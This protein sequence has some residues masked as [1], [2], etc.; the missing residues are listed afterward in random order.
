MRST[1]KALAVAAATLAT[2][3]TGVGVASASTTRAASAPDDTATCAP[4]NLCLWSDSGFSGSQ[5]SADF[6]DE[7]SGW[8]SVPSSV[9]N[10]TS[11]LVNYRDSITWVA[12]Y[13][14]GTGHSACLTAGFSI[15]NLADV[16][17][18]GY[19]T[20]MNDSITSYKFDTSGTC[21]QGSV[22]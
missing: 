9:N 15:S 10:T 13:A 12:Q 4:Y 17:W 3:T 19:T 18:P 1:F 16:D 11:S 14:G 5:F 8:N 6:F 7:P 22:P 2:L 21:P 20:P